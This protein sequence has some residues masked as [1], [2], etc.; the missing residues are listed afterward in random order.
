MDISVKHSR[1][2]QG[3]SSSSHTIAKRLNAVGV[4]INKFRQRC[5]NNRVFE[6]GLIMD[7]I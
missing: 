4:S 1:K 6:S 2:P 7:T 5:E 3:E